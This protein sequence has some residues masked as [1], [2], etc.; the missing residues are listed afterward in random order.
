MQ[1]SLLYTEQRPDMHFFMDEVGILE[2]GNDDGT[3]DMCGFASTPARD[4]Q[5]EITL[6]EGLNIDPLN[7]GGWI[8]W[9]H[10]NL[11]LIGWTTKAD[12]RE[13]PKTGKRSLYTEFRLLKGNPV[14]QRVWDIAKSLKENK[15]PRNLG[16]SVEGKKRA[17]ENGV[18]KKA[19]IFGIAVTPYPVNPEASADVLVK[20][21]IDPSYIVNEDV[22][23]FESPGDV[24]TAI[25]GL[26]DTLKKAMTTGN[27]VGGETQSG[28]GAFREEDLDDS[29]LMLFSDDMISGSLREVIASDPKKSNAYKSLSNIAAKRGGL[30]K[31]EAALMLALFGFDIS[32]CLAE[33]GF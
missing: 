26:A 25:S 7:K 22:F 18:I 3:W 9:N 4:R 6:Q 30:R 1:D 19:D 17:V 20:G 13:H 24:A 11:M 2:K 21:M 14:A 23:N 29:Q 33:A 31:S 10:N 27:D 5:D 28:A 15:A 8:N 32:K 12:F 16:L